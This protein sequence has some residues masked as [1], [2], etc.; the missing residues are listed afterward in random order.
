MVVFVFNVID[1]GGSVIVLDFEENCVV[2][3]GC[4]F[5]YYGVGGCEDVELFDC[6]YVEL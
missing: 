2:D 1:D 4:E 5:G 6:G 3:C